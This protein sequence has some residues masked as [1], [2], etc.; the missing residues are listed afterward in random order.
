[1]RGRLL[2]GLL[3]FIYLIACIYFKR[4][5]LILMVF[6]P[7]LSGMALYIL[8]LGFTQKKPVPFFSFLSLSPE[9]DHVYQKA[10]L[11]FLVIFLI[12][13]VLIVKTVYF[14]L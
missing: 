4:G 9:Y 3:L 2:T 1:M 12:A 10:F 6:V 5:D 14:S 11:Y 8:Y 7:L 13:L